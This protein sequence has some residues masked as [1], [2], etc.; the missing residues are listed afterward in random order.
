MPLSIIS[1]SSYGFNCQFVDNQSNFSFLLPTKATDL[2]EDGDYDLIRKY[3]EVLN[4]LL[5]NVNIGR[6]DI[7]SYNCNGDYEVTFL[8]ESN[9]ISIS[10]SNEGGGVAFSFPMD[11]SWWASTISELIV[12]AQ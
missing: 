2:G 4:S 10:C 7:L 9:S 11:K 5:E 8:Y 3:K 1:K 6:T 12:M